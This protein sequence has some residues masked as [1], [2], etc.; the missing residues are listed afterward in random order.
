M[1][2]L[3]K[4]FLTESARIK[5]VI[6]SD[7]VLLATIE[8]AA[9]ECRSRL[10]AGGTIFT[11]GN[12]GSTCD[13]MHFAEELVARYKR[14]RPGFKAMH[15][16]DP[17]TITCWAN[18]YTFET[19]FARQAETFCSPSDVL[20]GLSTSGNSKNI[21]NAVRTAKEKGTFTIG[22]AGKD[23]GALKDA[24]DL[25]IIVPSNETD[26]IQESHI[27]IIH[28]LCELIEREPL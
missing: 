6:A 16:M 24:C 13:A 9:I 8:K 17:G 15:L 19:A 28:I 21:L 27:T 7:D 20:F 5:S 4:Q 25:C 22:L 10:A 26:R 23:G 3:A 14:E 11:C 1:K 12:G 2:T 18:D